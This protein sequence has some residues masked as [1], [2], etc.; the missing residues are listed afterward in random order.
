MTGLKKKV[1]SSLWLGQAAV[2]F[3]L[4]RTVACLPQFT[5]YDF[6]SADHYLSAS[7][8]IR[9]VSRKKYLP[10][11][12]F[13]LSW[14]TRQDFF[15]SPDTVCKHLMFP[16]TN[17]TASWHKIVKKRH[18]YTLLLFFIKFIKFAGQPVIKLNSVCKNAIIS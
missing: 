12:K 6:Q 16:V 9:Q 18:H 1:N 7:L 8:P 11:R 15:S 5:F 4:P 14:T 17:I 10:G 13:F 2:K 3:Y